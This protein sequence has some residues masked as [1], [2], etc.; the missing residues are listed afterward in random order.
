M[1]GVT[2]RRPRILITA[3]TRPE[4][5]K[6][7]PLIRHLREEDWADVRVLATAQH[8][9]LLDQVFRFFD[10]TP[11]ID[12]N[13]MQPDQALAELTSRLI[14]AIDQALDVEE[15]DIVLTQGDTTTV[16]T[17]ALACFYRRIPVGHVEAG[18]RTHD[19]HYPFP[20]EINRVIVSRLCD[21]HFAPTD[22]A[23]ENLTRE[24]VDKKSVHVTGNTVIDALLWTAS[25]AE[26]PREY[27]P[28]D[29]RRL[30][31]V[32]AHRRENF[33]EPLRE[34]CNAI[35]DLVEARDVEVLYPVHPNPAV[36]ATTRELLGGLPGVRLVPPMDYPQFVAAMKTAHLI[37]TD[38][39]GVQEE[40]PSLGKP[41]LVLRDETERPEGIEAGTAVLVGPNRK[42]IVA[43]AL[44][45]L[46]DP[47]AYDRMA[48]TANPYGDGQATRRIADVVR[49]FVG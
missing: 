8:R 15:P 34:I 5:I 46:D 3:G 26:L 32:T 29:G 16:M 22:S 23:R 18:L 7:A 33:G 47:I 11:D 14:P 27:E 20:E 48:K 12:L 42:Q 24:G 38:S 45:L 41:V 28:T 44:E 10:I 37:L 49:A 39:G 17:T 13:I 35:N 19:R 6:L 25:R 9:E 1:P 36:V 43:K 31:L 40:A 4:A 30:V 21:L 2:R